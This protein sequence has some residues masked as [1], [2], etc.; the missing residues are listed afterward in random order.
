MLRLVTPVTRITDQRSVVWARLGGTRTAR[1]LGRK[2]YP[3]TYPWWDARFVSACFGGNLHRR[4]QGLVAQLRAP[5]PGFAPICPAAD[6]RP[7]DV[8]ARLSELS[9]ALRTRSNVFP[10]CH[11]GRCGHIGCEPPATPFTDS[12]NV[13]LRA[14]PDSRS[15]RAHRSPCPLSHTRVCSYLHRRAQRTS[16]D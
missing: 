14:V 5:Y 9:A 2:E 4:V 3:T 7:F 16:A 8:G 12:R 11:V 1:V 13:D 6:Q 10:W 15:G